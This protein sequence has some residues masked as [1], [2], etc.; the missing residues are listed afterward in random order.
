MR[1]LHA[2]TESVLVEPE[3]PSRGGACDHQ[4]KHPLQDAETSEY[5]QDGVLWRTLDWT[6]KSGRRTNSDGR[7]MPTCVGKDG[8]LSPTAQRRWTLP[9]GSSRSEKLRSLPSGLARVPPAHLGGRKPLV[10]DA[11]VDEALVAFFNEKY[12]LGY[13]SSTGGILHG[14]MRPLLSGVREAR[15]SFLATQPSRP[16]GL[17]AP[18]PPLRSRDPHVWCTWTV[19]IL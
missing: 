5:Q 17:E 14:A 6:R 18:A 11:E 3:N 10:A 4:H 13:S 12:R 16:P 15:E 2:P 19:L 9:P 7:P 1:C 8:D